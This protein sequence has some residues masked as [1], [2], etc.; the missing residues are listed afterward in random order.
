MAVVTKRLEWDKSGERLYETGIEKGV[1]YPISN[2]QYQSGVAWNGLTAF[3]ES[4]SGAENTDLYAD[5]IKYLSM[6]SA[7]TFGG[8]IE[9]YMYPDEFA[10][11]DGSANVADGVTIGQQTR[12]GFGF[13]YRTKVGNDTDGNEHGDKIHIVYGCK[14]SPSEKNYQTINDS[15]DAI[16]FSW[17]VNSTPVNVTNHKPTSCLVI[18][19]TKISEAALTAIE[20]ALYGK[21]GEEAAATDPKILMPDEVIAIITENP[22]A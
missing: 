17:E 13:C 5:N 11:C 21:N 8:T 7:E 10:E 19:T 16:T 9:A 6:Q 1:L 22:K 20:D 14:C 2:G 4:P 18:D 12:K 3:T 15:P